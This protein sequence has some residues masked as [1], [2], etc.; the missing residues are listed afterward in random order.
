MKAAGRSPFQR[1]V[2]RAYNSPIGL[3]GG[4]YHGGTVEGEAESAYLG[5][6]RR[7]VLE[8]VG[9]FDE[10]IRRGEDWE[11]NL[12]IR[13]A[14]YLVWFDPALEV[15][16]WPR[17]SWHRLARQFLATGTVARRAR[18]SLRPGQLAPV[19]RSAGAGR[20]HRA[21]RRRRH[22]A[23]DGRAVGMVVARSIHRLSAGDRVRRPRP[24]RYAG[25]RRSNLLDRFSHLSDSVTFI[26]FEPDLP[27]LLAQADVV[28]RRPATTPSASCCCPVGARSSSRCRDGPGTAHPRPPVRRARH[29]RRRR[30]RRPH[31]RRLPQPC[32]RSAQAT[33]QPASG[34]YDFRRSAPPCRASPAPTCRGSTSPCLV[35]S[36]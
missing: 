35:G 16:Y 32:P 2:A 28:G 25:Q 33:P 27:L 36:P 15:I 34:I 22:P 24:G 12:R 23:G 10:T 26:E 5:V 19:L 31:P 29:L 6:M 7:A 30:A 9:L 17:E 8:E 18:A 1:A 14:G 21:R 20:H 3:G 4:A 11:L 13:R